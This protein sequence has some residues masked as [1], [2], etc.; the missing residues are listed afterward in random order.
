MKKIIHSCIWLIGKLWAFFYTNSSKSRLS[1]IQ[2]ILYT[3]WLSREFKRISKFSIILYPIDLVGGKYI[4]IG[5]SCTIGK[6][7]VLSAWDKYASD[8]FNPQI[9]IGNNVAI[10]DDSHITAIN[11]IEIGDFVLTGKKITITDNAHGKSNFKLLSLP[12]A[13]RPLYSEG[14]VIIEDRVW[15]GDKVT[16]LPNVRIGKNAII[17]ANAV[18]TRDIPANCVAGGIPAKVIKTLD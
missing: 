5:D 15:I 3:A 9:I 7:T 17:G 14:P 2:N 1:V 4:S 18:V 11:R 8:T 13:V 16:I 10:G 12:P 6:R